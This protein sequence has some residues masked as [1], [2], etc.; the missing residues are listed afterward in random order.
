MDFLYI[1]PE[2]PP[3][4]AHF[5][6]QLHNF[7]VRVWGIGEADF[8]FMPQSLRSALDW[9][10]RTDLHDTEAVQY[11]LD[12]LLRQ[13]RACG[14][15]GSFDLVE[16]HNEQWLTL[17]GMINEKFGI[18]GIKKRDLPRLKKKSRMKQLFKELG[19][20]V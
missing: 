9:Y 12:E 10:V 17:E 15:P 13:K 11:A 19:R 1:S 18:D 16:S 2:F 3:N 8:Y 5:I 6:E 14:R 4:Y 7:G 20:N